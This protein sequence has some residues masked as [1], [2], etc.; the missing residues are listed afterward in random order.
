MK[1]SSRAPNALTNPAAATA[2]TWLKDG[3]IVQ[4][5]ESGAPHWTSALGS[6]A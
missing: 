6:L 5:L 2:K 4:Q 3:F 1:A